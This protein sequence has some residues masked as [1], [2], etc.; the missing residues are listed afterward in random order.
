MR[1]FSLEKGIPA[2]KRAIVRY[3]AALFAVT[4]YPALFGITGLS[5]LPVALGA[6]AGFLLIGLYGLKS[7]SGLRW[8]RAL[9]FASLLYLPTL[10][11]SLILSKRGGVPF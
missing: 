11:L 8:A 10:L 7:E 5:Y 2:T 1:V 4:L 3:L 9:F 6:G